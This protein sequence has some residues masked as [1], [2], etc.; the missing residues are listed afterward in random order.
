MKLDD[1]VGAEIDGVDETV[2]VPG[3]ELN[4]AAADDTSEDFSMLEDLET[5]VC[6]AFEGD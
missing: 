5:N 6:A 2:V 4:D 3:T 1:A